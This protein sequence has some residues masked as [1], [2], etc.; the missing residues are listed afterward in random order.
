VAV[1]APTV[2]PHGP[3]VCP[4]GEI[5]RLCI[6]LLSG[7]GDVVHGLPL[8]DDIA[9]AVPDAEVTWIAEPAPAQV[10][11]GHP[12]LHRLY[13]F[14]PRD[15]IRGVLE[16][17]REMSGMRAD[18]T[19]NIQRYFKSVWPTLFSGAPI[20]VGLPRSK[21][22]D[23]VRFFHTHL[24]QDGPWKHTQDIFLDFRGALGVPRD[25]PVTWNLRLLQEEEEEGRAF[26]ATLSGKPVAS[27]VLASANPQKDCPSELLAEVADALAADLGFEVILLGGPSRRERSMVAQIRRQAG[28]PP[29]DATGDSVRRLMTRIAGSSLVIAPDTGPLHLAHAMGVPVI[30]LFGHTNPWR[31]GPYRRFRDL[32][33]DRYTDPGAP[34][35]PADY[36]PK[37]GRMETITVRDVLEKVEVARW[38]YL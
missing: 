24:L 28:R 37:S 15:G 20:R 26:L 36:L 8:L 2:S 22:R 10:L 32:V 9:Q 34:P 18:V 13:V 29:V 27:L 23:G 7:I 19:L 1:R 16:L 35:D 17:R 21:T 38:R 6:V 5:R 30:G 25:A 33:I 31:V 4:L 11:K 12:G 3:P 14:R